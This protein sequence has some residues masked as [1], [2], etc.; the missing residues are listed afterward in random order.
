[1]RQ[2]KGQ[3]CNCSGHHQEKEMPRF[4]VQRNIAG[5]RVLGQEALNDI[6]RKSRQVISGMDVPYVGVETY[7]KDDAVC[8]IHVA[9]SA[10]VIYRRAR[11]GGFPADNVIEIDDG[12]EL[13]PL[14]GVLSELRDEFGLGG[15]GC[16]P[17]DW[18]G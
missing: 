15:R 10:D 5:A 12:N 13:R 2:T 1:M 18:R 4:I 16:S 17:W 8:C 7:V 3:I 9:E 11:E 14:S 6:A